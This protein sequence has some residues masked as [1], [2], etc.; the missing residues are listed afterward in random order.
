L[1]RA[2]L[3]Y[4]SRGI[5][6]PDFNGEILVTEGI[7]KQSLPELQGVTWITDPAQQ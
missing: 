2:T 1:E 4:R 7:Q 5:Y 6:I 3:E